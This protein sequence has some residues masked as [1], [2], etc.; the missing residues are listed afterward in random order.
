MSVFI[1]GHHAVPRVN[2][3]LLGFYS[4]RCNFETGIAFK[5]LIQTFHKLKLASPV[6]TNGVRL[7]LHVSSRKVFL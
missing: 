5:K 3:T 6:Q 7:I 1:K 4:H 2:N